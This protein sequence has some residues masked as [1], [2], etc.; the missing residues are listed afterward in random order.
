VVESDSNN[1]NNSSVDENFDKYL[2]SFMNK[3][4]Q[5]MPMP[6]GMPIF[7]ERSNG[8]VAFGGTQIQ[9][10][11]MQRTSVLSSVKKPAIISNFKPLQ[12]TAS[13]V[14]VTQP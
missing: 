6:E 10:P 14:S 8:S 3:E 12:S 13:I 4:E 2:P 5:T 1:N 11:T 9:Q 7:T